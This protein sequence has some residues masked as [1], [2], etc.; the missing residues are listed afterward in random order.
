V[1]PAREFSPGGLEVVRK[2]IAALRSGKFKQCFGEYGS[3]FTRCAVGV[4]DTISLDDCMINPAI[5]VTYQYNGNERGL[6][7]LNDIEQLS[8]AQIADIVE[9]KFFP[10]EQT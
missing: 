8:F 1:S 4:G 7:G 3:G 5:L 2:H 6:V 9:A 10:Q